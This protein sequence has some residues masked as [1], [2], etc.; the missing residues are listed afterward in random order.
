MRLLRRYL[1]VAVEGWSMYPTYADGDRLLA[2]RPK[3]DA[4]PTAG[5]I[6]V[7]PRPDERDGWRRPLPA[8]FAASADLFVKRVAASA[9]DEV[10]A[11]FRAAVG[12]TGPEC[13]VPPG[14]LLLVGDHAGSRD[15]RQLGYCPVGQVV[16]LVVRRISSSGHEVPLS[17][18]NPD[19][20]HER[21]GD[22]RIM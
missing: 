14:M 20:P 17:V 1:V 7:V 11:D 13:R 19:V 6:V 15:S 3:R 8:G 21:F 18:L 16:A 2:R 12:A 22:I 9:G 10:P 5:A 4:K